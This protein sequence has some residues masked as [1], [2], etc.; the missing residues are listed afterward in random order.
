M[1][2][3]IS[4]RFKSVAAAFSSGSDTRMTRHQYPSY[5]ENAFATKSITVKIQIKSDSC[6]LLEPQVR[7]A[8]YAVFSLFISFFFSRPVRFVSEPA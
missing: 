4:E 8:R 7:P 5:L 6:Q 1:V 2:A 3:V